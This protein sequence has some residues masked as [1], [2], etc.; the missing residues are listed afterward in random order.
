MIAQLR[1]IKGWAHGL[2]RESVAMYFALRHPMIPRKAK[3]LGVFVVAYALSPIDLIPDFI[4]VLGFLD[5]MILLPWA[6][7][8]FKQM[9]PI[10][11]IVDSRLKANYWMLT[12]GKRPQ[13]WLGAFLIMAFWWTVIVAVYYLW[14]R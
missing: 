1:R 10:K 12:V 2:K 8:L 11:V 7:W 3:W 6:I 13:S 14:W 4:P 9:L 5:E